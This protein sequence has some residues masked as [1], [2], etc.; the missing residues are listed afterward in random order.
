MR[1]GR[2]SKCCCPPWGWCAR[3]STRRSPRRSPG[4]PAQVGYAE[5]ARRL[6]GRGALQG[7]Y[8]RRLVAPAAVPRATGIRARRRASPGALRA[9]LVR[10]ARR[11]GR[12][13]WLEEDLAA[14]TVTTRCASIRTTPGRRSRD[15]RRST[16]RA[17]N[18]RRRSPRG[19]SGAPA[20]ATGRAA[21]SWTTRCCAKSCCACRARWRRSRRC[22]RCRNPWC[23]NAA[24]SC[25]TGA[26]RGNPDPPPPLPRRERPDAAQV[27]L[28]KRL[29][30]S[31]PR[32]AKQLDISAEVLATRRELEKLA[33]GRRDVSPA[34]RLARPGS[35]R[36]V[37]S[38]ALTCG[39]QPS[40]I[41]GRGSGAPC[42]RLP[43]G[44]AFARALALGSPD[45]A[46]HR[47][48]F[49]LVF[50]R[51]TRFF[52]QLFS[53]QMLHDASLPR[54]FSRQFSSLYGPAF[55]RRFVCED[56]LRGL[57]RRRF[58][59]GLLHSVPAASMNSRA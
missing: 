44:L 42:G 52:R 14:S 58:F 35:G 26:G 17:S 9:Q 50:R 18:S 24:R 27:A 2:I 56:F 45:F 53:P 6:L 59:R 4:I 16:R 54:I 33:S 41:G 36:K 3:C 22:P 43:R 20:S 15:C 40:R 32:C 7:P 5:L 1:R 8:P 39:R 57:L 21:G 19:A 25:C 34:A 23:A 46:H 48:T 38:R 29:A 13:A 49:I 10:D 28:V 11:Q 37:V 12:L 30:E 47:L 31:P 55:R 51:T